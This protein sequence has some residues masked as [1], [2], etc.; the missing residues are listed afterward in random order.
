MNSPESVSVVLPVRDNQHLV[1]QR[2]EHVLGA[3]EQVSRGGSEVLV[4]DD[5]SKDQ[6]V[7]VVQ[8][9]EMIHCQVRL[10]RH[11][12]PRG[13][14]AAGQTGLER[15]RGELIFIHESQLELRVEDLERLLLLSRDP[16]VVAARAE[17]TRRPVPDELL[18]RLSGWGIHADQAKL[19]IDPAVTSTSLQMVRRPHLK[20]LVSPQ[21]GRHRLQSTTTIDTSVET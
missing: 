1:K 3:L 6:T 17:S 10:I 2:I 20:T 14:E 4:V 7:S 16:A 12:R 9:L 5:G 8:S 11:S 19:R 21:A 15:A 13:I 18:R